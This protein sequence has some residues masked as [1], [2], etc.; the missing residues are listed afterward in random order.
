MFFERSSIRLLSILWGLGISLM[1]TAQSEPARDIREHVS[2]EKPHHSILGGINRY[3]FTHDLGTQNSDTFGYTAGYEYHMPFV[4][5]QPSL[6]LRVEYLETKHDSLRNV[7]Y[8]VVP[9]LK[10]LAIESMPN[11]SLLLGMEA[12]FWTQ[13]LKITKDLV[14]HKDL[15]FGLV[16]GVQ[17]CVL[18]GRWGALD[19]A[20]DY[21]LQEVDI[22][23][24]Y[25]GMGLH[26][27]WSI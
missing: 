10:M 9:Y 15:L 5:P 3:I 18:Q 6:G 7:H 2:E 26:Y 11:L 16:L 13:H 22:R 21:H 23:T 19:I 8:L 12:D 4:S 25:F 1:L 14:L 27:R 24:T 17:S 20:L